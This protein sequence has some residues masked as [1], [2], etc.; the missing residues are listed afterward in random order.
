M[1][2]IGLDHCTNLDQ[3][4][5]GLC[6]PG[7]HVRLVTQ[8]YCARGKAITRSGALMMPLLRLWMVE[9]APDA[10]LDVEYADRGH[11]PCLVY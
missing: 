10:A 8:L 3:A 1:E 5:P 6:V 9:H 11:G 4:G 7:H 2:A